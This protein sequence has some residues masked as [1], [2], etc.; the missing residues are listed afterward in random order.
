MGPSLSEQNSL[1]VLGVKVYFFWQTMG[2]NFKSWS[3]KDKKPDNFW[4]IVQLMYHLSAFE[5][6]S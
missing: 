2:S 4:F 3:P 1:G 5:M 6:T